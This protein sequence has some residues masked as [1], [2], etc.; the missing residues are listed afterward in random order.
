MLRRHIQGN[1]SDIEELKTQLLQLCTRDGT[2]EQAKNAVYTLTKL[3]N[4]KDEVVPASDEEFC[5]LLKAISSP[6]RLKISHD[7][8]EATKLISTLSALSALSDRAPVLVAA[9]HRGKHAFTF[10]LNVVLQGIQH[11]DQD[12]DVYSFDDDGGGADDDKE[13]TEHIANTP[14]SI[15]LG[16]TSLSSRKGKH[17]TPE[18]HTS[19]LEDQNLSI[20]CRRICAAV[21]FLVS[22]LRSMH[23]L[24]ATLKHSN[25]SEIKTI[26]EPDESHVG[27]LFQLLTRMVIDQGNPPSIRDRKMCKSRQDRAALRQ[28]AS[29]SL[30]RLC[31][32]RLDLGRL[33]MTKDMLHSLGEAFMDEE[34]T[35]RTAAMNELADLLC[36]QGVYREKMAP[37]PP[38]LRFLAFITLCSDCDSNGKIHTAAKHCI[39]NLRKSADILHTRCCALGAENKYEKELKYQYVPE[40]CLPFVYWLLVYR[41][42]TP[43]SDEDEVKQKL[44]KRRLKFLLE[45][46]VQSLGDRSDNISF[47]LR[48]TDVLTHYSPVDSWPSNDKRS[49]LSSLKL[50]NVCGAARR[51]L[52]SMVKKDHNLVAFPGTINIPSRLFRLVKRSGTKRHAISIVGTSAAY[53][54]KSGQKVSSNATP[55]GLSSTRRTPNSSKSQSSRVHFSPET[56]VGVTTMDRSSLDSAKI[57][58]SALTLGSSPPSCLKTISVSAPSPDSSSTL[59]SQHKHCKV[60]HLDFGEDENV[61]NKRIRKSLTSRL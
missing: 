4:P 5:N 38:P 12:S 45:P 25:P 57:N 34:P 1:G 14:V 33:H 19:L 47:L 11:T 30:L 59:Y 7:G 26:P 52:M 10:A 54:V 35:S 15:R 6:S 13:T 28:C 48:M 58:A 46:L 22:H 9:S 27:K 61:Q 20:T 44:L 16:R 2:P 37:Q 42:E 17:Q 55:K 60:D 40:Y 8:K 49:S 31:D 50:Q 53:S 24:Q 43:D 56:R 23:L 41:R 51:V 21:E 36:G 3:L 29:V 32:P 39:V 18:T